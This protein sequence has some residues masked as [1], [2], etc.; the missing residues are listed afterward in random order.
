VSGTGRRRERRE[1]GG[2]ERMKVRDAYS[3]N[4]SAGD[5]VLIDLPVVS[6]LHI[7]TRGR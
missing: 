2:K 6:Y 1:E 7:P 5:I 3:L 4:V